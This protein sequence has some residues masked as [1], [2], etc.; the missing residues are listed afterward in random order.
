MSKK[1]LRKSKSKVRLAARKSRKK[2]VDEYQQLEPRQMLATDIGLQF[3]GT[4]LGT[5]TTS[6]ETNPQ[7]DIGLNHYVEVAEGSFVVHDRDTGT[8]LET[9][10]LDEFFL[11]AGASVNNGTFDPQVIFDHTTNRWFAAA[12]GGNSGNYIYVAF[13]NTS[14]PTGVWK[15]RQFIGDSQGITLNEDVSLSVDQDAVYLATNN[16]GPLGG[17]TSLYSIPKS[18]LFLSSPTITNMSRFENLDPSYGRSIQVAVNFE[19]SDGKATVVGSGGDGS[20]VVVIADI[21]GAGGPGATL[22]MPTA[23]YTGTNIVDP[24]GFPVPLDLPMQEAAPSE[25]DPAGIN[26]NVSRELTGT[27]YEWRGSIYGA[28]TITTNFNM[29][30]FPEADDGSGDFQHGVLWFEIDVNNKAVVSQDRGDN[31]HVIWANNTDT[32][33]QTFFNPSVAVN[34]FGVMSIQFNSATLDL[35]ADDDDPVGAGEFISVYN[36]VGMFTNGVFKRAAHYDAPLAIQTGLEDYDPVGFDGTWGNSTAVRVDP[37]ESNTFWGVSAYANTGD[38]WT[39]NIVKMKPIEL[40]PFLEADANDNAIVISPQAEDTSLL[41]VTIDGVTTDV[42]PFEVL[43]TLSI[44]GHDGADTFLM[45]YTLGD[46]V[47]VNGLV[48]DGGFGTDV[49]ETNDPDGGEF[50]MNTFDHPDYGDNYPTRLNLFVMNDREIPVADSAILQAPDGTYNEIS[51]LVDV[52]Q[53]I[54]GPGDDLFRFEA[55]L[56]LGSAIGNDGD[57]TFQFAGEIVGDL[58]GDMVPDWTGAIGES[59]NG[60]AGLNTLDFSDMARNA[61]VEVLG[62]SANDGFDGRTLSTQGTTFHLLGG[63]IGGDNPTDQWRDISNIIGTTMTGSLPGDQFFGLNEQSAFVIDDENSSYSAGGKTMGFYQWETIFASEFD[64]SFDVIS[65]TMDPLSLNGLDGDDHYRFSSDAPNFMGTTDNIGGLIFALGGAGANTLIASNYGGSATEVLVLAQRISGMGE[66]VYR[67]DDGGTFDL[68]LFSSQFDDLVQLHSFDPLNTLEFR[69]FHGNDEFSIEDLSR[70]SVKVYGGEG[71]DLYVIGRIQG[72]DFRNLEIFDSV[73]RETDRV[74][75]RG[76]V[77]DEVYVIDNQTFEDLQV[78]YEGIEA[79]GV[80]GAGGDDVFHIREATFEIFVD[81]GDGNDI[82]NISSD[83]DINMGTTELLEQRV[84]IEGGTGTNAMNISNFSGLGRI[85]T[86]S[87]DTI[88]GL[89]PMPLTYVATGGTFSAISNRLSGIRIDGSDTGNDYF[90]VDSLLATTDVSVASH[91]GDD[92][93]TVRPAALGDVDLAGGDGRDLYRVWFVGSDNREMSINDFSDDPNRLEFFGSNEAETIEVTNFKVERFDETV[94]INGDYAFLS[95]DSYGGDD[96]LTMANSVAVT[97]YLRSGTDN[98]NVIISGTDGVNGVNIFTSYGDDSIEL[99]DTNADTFTRVVAEDGDDTI[100]VRSDALGRVNADGGQ[101]SDHYTVDL[102]GSENRFVSTRD[103]GTFGFDTIVVNATAANDDIEFRGTRLF[104]GDEK[105]AYDESAE[106]LELHTMDGNDDI[107]MLYSR[108]GETQI[109]TGFGMDEIYVSST[110]P[111]SSLDVDLGS[112]DDTITFNSTKDTTSTT[113]DGKEGDDRFNIGTGKLGRL[114]GPIALVGG[115]N[116]FGGEDEVIL[117]DSNT[118]SVINYFMAEFGIRWN[119]GPMIDGMPLFAGVTLDP[120]ID[121]VRINGTDQ[122]NNF[123]VNPSLNTR[124]FIDGNG[125]IRDSIN[126]IRAVETGASLNMTDQAFGEGFWDFTDG[127]QP[128]EFE[129]IEF[130][131]Q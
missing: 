117:D 80:E 92:R 76:T 72:V 8:R 98:D 1:K 65:N 93:L 105:V 33:R 51:T 12:H 57:D 90:G 83:A 38:R 60:G 31:A 32:S 39:T 85:V 102:V 131:Y 109:T 25:T 104:M 22:D 106:R 120:S 125:D 70:A 27:I 34:E 24:L 71:D 44:M 111:T 63:P 112:G 100:L 67:A 115:E 46:P 122:K 113:V 43:G 9:Q 29:A 6:L 49:I 11:N 13:S 88:V 114:R 30:P 48:L 121:F 77:L 118:T 19:D 40:T 69:S 94:F 55:G 20:G 128:V 82:F 50:I 42:I 23:L 28:S 78:I 79:F 129:E 66:I 2:Q 75:L 61:I 10:T 91:G 116:S 64:D 56:L 54:G 3:A 84:H 130:L 58:D 36:V 21:L 123:V 103:T 41:E 35:E 14:D 108:A 26:L 81:G 74:T 99:I 124:F 97:N 7:G 62:V 15:S 126:L 119:N 45:D 5:E 89:L 17:G 53:L 101:G 73:N 47:P 86:I 68:T 18:D 107:T 16:V 95:V 4:T 127:S 52:E 59:V 110:G 96:I 37:V 87:T